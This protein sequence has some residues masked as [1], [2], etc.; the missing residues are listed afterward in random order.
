MVLTEKGFRTRARKTARAGDSNKWVFT[1]T[2]TITTPGGGR[3]GVQRL[4]YGNVDAGKERTPRRDRRGTASTVSAQRTPPCPVPHPP[5]AGVKLYLNLALTS[6]PGHA[7]GR[8]DAP[9]AEPIGR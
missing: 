5:A 3:R 1:A 9:P 8:G 7:I 4:L 2:T 6:I